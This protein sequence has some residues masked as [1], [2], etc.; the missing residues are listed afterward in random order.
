MKNTRNNTLCNNSFTSIIYYCCRKEMKSWH[1][2]DLKCSQSCHIV[3]SLCPTWVILLSCE[4]FEAVHD[5]NSKTEENVIIDK[6][7]LSLVFIGVQGCQITF[8]NCYCSFCSCIQEVRVYLL[9]GSF[10]LSSLC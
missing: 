6:Y 5:I 1:F 4:V 10:S 2:V 9:N 8:N 7:L 3:V